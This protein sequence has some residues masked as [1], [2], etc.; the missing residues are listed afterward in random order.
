MLKTVE[1]VYQMGRVEL[2]ETPRD[3]R[4]SRVLV[5]FLENDAPPVQ[6]RVPGQDAGT[7]R[8]TPDFDA[9]LP[10]DL[11]QSFES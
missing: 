2:D 7:V 11:L 9:P 10:D 1:G 8:V 6:N 4:Q 5:T 3:V